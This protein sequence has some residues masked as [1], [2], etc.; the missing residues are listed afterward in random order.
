MKEKT[1]NKHTKDQNPILA[2]IKAKTIAEK[3]NS[4]KAKLMRMLTIVCML[5]LIVTGIIIY[6]TLNNQFTENHKNVLHETSN[7]I[8]KEAELFFQKYTTIAEQMAQ[9]KNIQNFLV[10]V[11]RRSDVLTNERAKI[12]RDTL[13]DTQKANDDVMLSAYIGEADPSYYYDDLSGI[14]DTDF[15]LSTRPYYKTVTDGV[16][17]ITEP[18]LD[19]ATGSMVITI[20]APVNVNGGVVGFT[21]IDITID[22]LSKVVGDATIGKSGYF[23]LLTSDN[24][25][26][27][28]KDSEN[29]LKTIYDISLSQNLID[30]VINSDDSVIDYTYNNG[31]FVGN[32]TEIG[33][34]GWKVLSSMPMDE[35]NENIVKLMTTIVIIYILTIIAM[36]IAIYI[37]S[38]RVTNPIKKLTDITNKL[39]DGEL[40]VNIDVKSDDEIG[41]LA[42]S[43]E[44]LTE[45]LKLYIVYIEES[46]GV[47]DEMAEGNL[48]SDLK[49]DY[50]GEFAKLKASLLHMADTFKKTIGRI[51]DSSN[52]IEMNAD[53]VSMGAQ[54]LAQGTT[55]QASAI[56]ELS[57]EINEIYTTIVSN[58]EYAEN[59]GGK[60][61]EAAREVEHGNV[62]MKEMLSAMD[63][64]SNSS[65]EIG[66][67]IKV[68][69]DIAF[70]TNILALNAAVE[71]ARAGAAGKGFAVVADEVRNL[72]GKS[73]EAAKQT[74]ALIENSINAI[75]KG[76]MLAGQA[77]KSLAGIVD[78]TNETNSL[79]NEIVKASSQQ[80]VSVNQIRSGIEQ[81]S[82]VIQENAASAESSAA[83]SEELLGQV[84]ILNDLVNKFNI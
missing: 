15:D 77:G 59:A 13:I 18:Y 29:M 71:A 55:E 45:R 51:K 57:A 56:E 81:I 27:Y 82:S 54:T 19:V 60:A 76:T 2:S 80:T 73:A 43:I 34:T 5:L 83:N 65:S 31:E 32:V 64:I 33:S 28:H 39:A 35:F 46:V 12:V 36:A 66:K 23:T 9:D 50:S 67:V 79:L 22:A 17:Y 14:S 69:D 42:K 52:S 53:Q 63:E 41:V 68:I 4:I 11:K 62:Q 84:H 58:E 44:K 61:L 70:Q 7:S 21:G 20:T 8:S 16:V 10:S 24:A 75:N 1:E 78:K 3:T 72:A 47:L 74:T 6:V 37:V 48:N 25:I 30:N 26:T 38:D 40:D 49:N